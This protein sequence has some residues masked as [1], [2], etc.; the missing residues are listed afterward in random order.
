[1]Q[2]LCFFLTIKKVE[3][4][5]KKE[6]RVPIFEDTKLDYYWFSIIAFFKHIDY[7]D[8]LFTNNAL[9]FWVF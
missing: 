2:K 8:V 4:V 1:M 6:Y 3:F 9:T 7:V 5:G